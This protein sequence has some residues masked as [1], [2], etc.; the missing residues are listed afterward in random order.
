MIRR[1]EEIGLD[2]SLARRDYARQTMKIE[3]GI[4]TTTRRRRSE[5]FRGLDVAGG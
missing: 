3:I 4:P 1:E 2:E 5:K